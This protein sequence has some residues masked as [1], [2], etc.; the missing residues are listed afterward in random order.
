MPGLAH[1]VE[2][3]KRLTLELSVYIILPTRVPLPHISALVLG[4]PGITLQWFVF[5]S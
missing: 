5:F 4:I 2:V 1:G 3:D